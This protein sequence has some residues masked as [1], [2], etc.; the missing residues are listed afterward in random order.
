MKIEACIPTKLSCLAAA[1]FAYWRSSEHPAGSHFLMVAYVSS[2]QEIAHEKLST[3]ISGFWLSEIFVSL[4]LVI[5]V[6][7]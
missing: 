4:T 2:M 3:I 6:I 1:F 7:S 5:V